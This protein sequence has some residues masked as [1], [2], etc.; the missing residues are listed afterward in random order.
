MKRILVA[1][2]H[3]IVRKGLRLTCET[4]FGLVD[5]DEADSCGSLM[6]ALKKKQYSHLILDL[7]LSDGLTMEIL[8]NI[9]G[10][11]PN[12]SILIFT[13]Q[14]LGIY[15]AALARHGV[16]HLISKIAPEAE[17]IR[18]LQDFLYGRESSSPSGASTPN[19]IFNRFT[20]REI[21]V[22]HYMV[23]GIGSVEIGRRLNMKSNTVSTFKRRI[24]DKSNTTNIIDLKE[25]ISLYK[26]A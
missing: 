1:D 6:K 16:K 5:V 21:E 25:F 10:L 14:P 9:R 15:K 8:P 2:D 17:T 18:L 20:P 7:V 12:L 13:M 19:A 4:Q 22:L 23:Q 11:F 3:S 26:D 24:F